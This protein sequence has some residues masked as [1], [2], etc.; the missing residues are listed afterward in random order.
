M[1][2]NPTT[3]MLFLSEEPLAQFLG[4]ADHAHSSAHDRTPN[5]LSTELLVAPALNTRERAVYKANSHNPLAARPRVCSRSCQNKSAV[6]R[7][8]NSPRGIS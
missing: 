3:V 6:R 7:L 8:K 1:Q 4:T 5:A 2:M